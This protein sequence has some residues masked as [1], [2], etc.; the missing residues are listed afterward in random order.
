MRIRVGG[1]IVTY[2]TPTKASRTLGAI[3]VVLAFLAVLG[4]AGWVEGLGT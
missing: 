3:L 1:V 4:I 2:P